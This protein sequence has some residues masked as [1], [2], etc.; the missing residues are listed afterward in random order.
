MCCCR[1]LMGSK[2][3]GAL[4]DAATRDIPVIFLTMPIEAEAKVQGFQA[5]AVDYITKPFQYEDL[6][7][8]VATHLR[9]QKLAQDMQEQHQAPCA[10]NAA[11]ASQVEER[12]ATLSQANA[13]LQEQIRERQRLEEALAAQR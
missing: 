10:A 1:I 6:L 13:L 8:Q 3:A 9:I 5:G 7:A 12:A 2:S 4:A 11:S